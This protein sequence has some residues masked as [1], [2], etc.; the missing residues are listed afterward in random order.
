MNAVKVA[1]II[2]AQYVLGVTAAVI[3]IGAPL[4]LEFIFQR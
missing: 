4:W 3:A 1:L 2:V